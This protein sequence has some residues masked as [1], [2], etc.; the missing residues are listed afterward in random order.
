MEYRRASRSFSVEFAALGLLMT[1]PMHGYE[2]RER[3][4]YDLGF[5]WRIASSQLYNVLHRLE[6]NEWIESQTEPQPGR[7]S[8]TVYRITPTGERAFWTWATSPVPHL[9]DVRVEFLAKIY[10]LRRLSPD[11]IPTLVDEEINAL[12]RL[13]QHLQKRHPLQSDD[14]AF[15]RYALSFRHGLIEKTLAW[16]EEHRH[17]LS[18]PAKE[19][20]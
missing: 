13:N 17:P 14:P 1:S 20:R 4:A 2:I 3:L 18:V 19:E 12:R 8:R 16:L 6:E 15:A 11:R 7:P 9:R 10:F 5:L